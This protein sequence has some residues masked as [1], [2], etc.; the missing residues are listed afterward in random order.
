M[1]VSKYV[2]EYLLLLDQL[3]KNK[4][5][6]GHAAVT[7]HIKKP[8]LKALGIGS[9]FI[10]NQLKYS[11][12]VLPGNYIEVAKE[13]HPTI[14]GGVTEYIKKIKLAR[15][16]GKSVEELKLFDDVSKR[17][18]RTLNDEDL[19]FAMYE[20]DIEYRSGYG[21]TPEIHSHKELIIKKAS[22]LAQKALDLVNKTFPTITAID[23][24]PDGHV[25]YN[26]QLAIFG[27]S[28]LAVN[29]CLI[30][31]KTKKD[32]KL[33]AEDGAQLFAY[34]LHKY[35]RDGSNYDKVYVLNPRF[36]LLEEVI[37]SN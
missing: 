3:Y 7:H 1:D 11:K 25:M 30:D 9:F 10:R 4:F 34:S 2:D 33:S 32:Y 21:Y 28:D 18:Y 8:E 14:C 13:E 19:A 23:F 35:M 29:N 17:K 37:L 5:F 20:P 24:H 12:K 26:N 22:L 27:D 16:V 31:F 15:Q 36:D 6:F